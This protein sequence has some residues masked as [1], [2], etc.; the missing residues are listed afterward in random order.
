MTEILVEKIIDGYIGHDESPA[1]EEILSSETIKW[2]SDYIF[3][4]EYED[5]SKVPLSW[6]ILKLF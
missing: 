2:P 6:K 1:A 4:G 3:E 5:F